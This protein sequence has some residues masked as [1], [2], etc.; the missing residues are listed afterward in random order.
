MTLTL[1]SAITQ[2]INLGLK[3]PHEIYDRLLAQLGDELVEIAR[4]HMADFIADRAR[5]RLNALRRASVAKITA[6]RIEPE[7]KLRSLWVPS[8]D[9]ITYKRIADMTAAD[10]DAR[11]D[12]LDRLASGISRHADWCRDV[13][14][15]IRAANVEVA[16][17]LSELPAL[18]EG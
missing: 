11:A 7:T 1:E 12:Y 2:Q 4:P 16:G 8:D 15:A 5:Q 18:G 17:G 14:A 3:D 13:A 10:F 6:G 9:A